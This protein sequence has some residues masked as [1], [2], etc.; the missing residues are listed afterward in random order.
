MG[1]DHCPD[2]TCLMRDAE[3]K[4]TTNEET[5]F[6]ENCKEFLLDKGWNLN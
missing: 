3:G 2:K 4:N 5:G 1:L 6:C